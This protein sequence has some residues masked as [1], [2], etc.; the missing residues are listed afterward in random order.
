M[1]HKFKGTGLGLPLSK[2]LAEL[3]G[4]EIA[5]ESASG[6][7]ATFSVTIPTIY[8]APA[9]HEDVRQAERLEPGRMT[10][11]ALDD[12]PADLTVLQTILR[13]SSYQLISTRSMA[14]AKRAA[15]LHQP[16]AVL[17]DVMIGEDSSCDFSPS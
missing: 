6:K 13:T 11:V 15:M 4:G 7:G 14:E 16:R 12:D 10:V 5:V 17:L 8:R 3:L 9:G 1:Q 2:R